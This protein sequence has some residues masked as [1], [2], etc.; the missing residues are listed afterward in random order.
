[1]LFRSLGKWQGTDSP[2]KCPMTAITITSDSFTFVQD[3]AAHPARVLGIGLQ[4]N[5]AGEINVMT[6]HEN[7]FHVIDSNHI[8]LYTP[9]AQCSYTR[10]G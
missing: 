9:F 2:T 4:G 1:M 8:Q 3:G 5:Q 6:S 7:V 10:A